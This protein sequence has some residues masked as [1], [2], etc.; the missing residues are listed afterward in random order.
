MQV[1]LISTFDLGR[2]PF[3]LA[4]P[5]AWLER[6]GAEVRCL[7]LAVEPLDETAVTKAELIAFFLPMHTATRLAIGVIDR[8]RRLAPATHLCAFGLYA[9]LNELLLRSVGV[10]TVLGGEFEQGLARLL[11]QL[12]GAAAGK[13]PSASDA[14]PSISL[15]RQRFLLPS[16]NSLPPLERYARVDLG[17]GTRRVV[18]TTEASRGCKHRCRHCPVV[19]VYDGQFRIVQRDVVLADIRQQIAR[20]AEHVTFADPDFFNG[21][22]H[23][24]EIVRA[25]HEEHPR[26]SYDVTIKIEHLLRHARHLP[27]LVETGCLLVTSA[28][29]SIDD[30][31]L[32]YLDKGHTRADFVAAVRLC[33]DVGLTLNPTFV[34]FHPWISRR[35]YLELL[36]L[37]AEL[38]LI[39]Q[40]APVQRALR[41]L[42][43]AGSRLLEL[44]ELR[45]LIGP[46][47]RRAL[48][49]PWFHPEPEV[50]QLQRAVEQTVRE[51]TSSRLGRVQT[52]VQVARLA[53][54]ALEAR[55]QRP[56]SP[57]AI[58]SAA[59]V[60]SLTIGTQ[61]PLRAPVPYL[62][63]PW[64]C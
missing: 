37:L 20:G 4:S 62:T 56:S 1:L 47:D 53:E 19:P 12:R 52:F 39:E 59:G 55:R 46:F 11:E 48:V 33:R 38:D 51:A 40:V 31:V 41:L 6:A 54:S 21:P 35:G 64:Y 15:E 26:V 14:P 7:D 22:R 23:A 32:G 5:A 13:A 24:L 61:A 18:A 42:I 60:S 27:A 30:S 8:V 29:E 44:A 63:E 36:E 43:P 28:V 34:A 50:D 16:R 49:Y 45:A 9:P 3:G 10:T 58:S 17:D 2:Q 57:K 25:L